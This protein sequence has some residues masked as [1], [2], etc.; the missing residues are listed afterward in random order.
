M[1]IE[2]NIYAVS[3]REWK[4]LL[5]YM[6]AVTWL[7]DRLSCCLFIELI[8]TLFRLT[9]CSFLLEQ[10]CI[11]LVVRLILTVFISISSQILM[12]SL[13]YIKDVSGHSVL[14]WIAIA[15][16]HLLM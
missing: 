16:R 15:N 14:V 12:F 3:E 2:L 9:F 10:P 11:K 5:S 7:V 6:T 8:N 13:N 1:F 4:V